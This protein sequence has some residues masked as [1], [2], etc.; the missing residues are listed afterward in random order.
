MV[1]PRSA[2]TCSKVTPP[3]GFCR[4]YSHGAATARRSFSVGGSSS[5]AT[6][7]MSVFPQVSRRIAATHPG[8]RAPAVREPAHLDGQ[9]QHRFE[10]ADARLADL[11]LRGG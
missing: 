6:S 7:A 4:K 11:R 2:A 8:A 3:P 5:G 1:K 9:F 10:Q